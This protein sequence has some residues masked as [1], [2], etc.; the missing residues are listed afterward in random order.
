[1]QTDNNNLRECLEI[2]GTILHPPASATDNVSCCLQIW[3]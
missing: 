1:M 2:L 3:V